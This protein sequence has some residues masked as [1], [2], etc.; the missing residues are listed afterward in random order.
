MTWQ[1]THNTILTLY[2]GRK[3][4]DVSGGDRGEREQGDRGKERKKRYLKLSR[5]YSQNQFLEFNSVGGKLIKVVTRSVLSLVLDV[6]EKQL[7]D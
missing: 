1:R 7:V 5:L 6:K 3:R 2:V 4:T